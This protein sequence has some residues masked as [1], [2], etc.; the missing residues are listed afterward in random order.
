MQLEQFLGL[1]KKKEN[2]VGI[3]EIAGY[4]YFLLFPQFFSKGFF[5]RVVKNRDC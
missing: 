2:I 3:G 5:F 4:Q 1:V